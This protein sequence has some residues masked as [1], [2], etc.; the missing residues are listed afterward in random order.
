MQKR[1]EINADNRAFAESRRQDG[2]ELDDRDIYDDDRKVTGEE[3]RSKGRSKREQARL[4]RMEER[5]EELQGRVDQ[6]K[7]KE[8][9]TMD[10]FRA[11]A[12]ERFGGGSG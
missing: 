8:D 11:M 10:M 7:R 9:K 2:L 6:M 3:A 4:E 5:K 1:R 12:R